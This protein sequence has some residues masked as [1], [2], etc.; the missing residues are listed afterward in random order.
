MHFKGHK[1]TSL[2]IRIPKTGS[3]SIIDVLD[4]HHH[5]GYPI[6]SGYLGKN[7]IGLAIH[8]KK[9]LGDSYYNKLFVFSFVRNPFSR[10]VSSWKYASGK[11]AGSFKNFCKNLKNLSNFGNNTEWHSTEQWVHLYDDKNNLIVDYV[12]RLESYQDDFNTISKKIGIPQ[13]KL[14][15]KNK[16]KHKH[17]TEYYDD[18]TIELVAKKYAKDIEYFGYKFG[19]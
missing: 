7:A 12:G 1:F 17:Y 5:V 3:C 9:V 13:Q 10:A 4:N 18:E 19:E 11:H 15:H 6:K 14:P 8:S 16:T 2:Y